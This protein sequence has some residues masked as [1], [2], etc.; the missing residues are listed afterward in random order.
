MCFTHILSFHL[1]IDIT[2]I[3][4]HCDTEKLPLSSICGG[5]SSRSVEVS[6]CWGEKSDGYYFIC[7]SCGYEWSPSIL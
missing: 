4:T 7:L 2:Y 6:W 3:S 5:C 1:V